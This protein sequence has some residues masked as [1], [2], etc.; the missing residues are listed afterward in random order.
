MSNTKKAL[1]IDFLLLILPLNSIS[2]AVSYIY[3]I[4]YYWV[5]KLITIK[6]AF[7]CLKYH[8]IT[9]ILFFRAKLVTIGAQNSTR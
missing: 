1:P 7:V 6:S 3:I 2:K 5:F 8:V 9:D 4:P